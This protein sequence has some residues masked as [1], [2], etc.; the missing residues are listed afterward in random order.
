MYLET[1]KPDTRIFNNKNNNSNNHFLQKLTENIIPSLSQ[2]YMHPF[3]TQL[4]NGRLLEGIPILTFNF[5][6]FKCKFILCKAFY[7]EPTCWI[8]RGKPLLATFAFMLQGDKRVEK[9]NFVE[10]NVTPKRCLR[11]H[12]YNK[13]LKLWIKK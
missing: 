2:Y 12:I 9:V 8:K 1:Q 4:R 3:Y 6:H 7:Q 10:A 13:L 5:G 11:T